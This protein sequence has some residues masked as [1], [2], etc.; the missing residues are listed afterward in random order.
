MSMAACFHL[1][2]KAR[3]KCVTVDS[4]KSW[5]SSNKTGQ[6]KRALLFVVSLNICAAMG[7]GHKFL[8]H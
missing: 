3:A 8:Q 1:L 4:I 7:M 5:I 6:I 2:P